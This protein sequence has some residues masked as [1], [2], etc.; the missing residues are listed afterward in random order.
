MGSLSAL[1]ARSPKSG[2]QPGQT[3]SEDAHGESVLL[4]Q[5]LAGL[6]AT[7]LVAASLSSLSPSSHGL[8][9]FSPGLSSVH[10]LLGHL[11]LDL[12][13]TWITQDDL[14]LRLLIPSAK[15]VF[16]ECGHTQF[17]NTDVTFGTTLRPAT[18]PPLI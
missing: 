15:S 18:A 11:S 5:L 4:S 14:I 17:L 7:W 9:L 13:P 2:C 1:K 8:I 10:H 12:E 3:R 6:A 16:L